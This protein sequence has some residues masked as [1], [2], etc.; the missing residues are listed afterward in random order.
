[1]PVRVEVIEFIIDRLKC[2]ES[3]ELGLESELLLI[4]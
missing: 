3:Y 2:T 4:E 1:M